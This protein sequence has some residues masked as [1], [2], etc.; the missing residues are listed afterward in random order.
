MAGVKPLRLV[1]SG[2]CGRMGS[3]IIEEILK[4]PA[5][6]ELV[7]G[8]EHDGHPHLGKPLPGAPKIRV[9]KDV[10]RLFGEADLVID[11]T[12]PEA[13]LAHAE[14]AA[15]AA[16]GLVIGTTGFSP[17]QLTRL[18]ELS[19]QVPIFWSPN[20]SIGIVIVRR[21]IASVSK[22]LF[23]FGLTEQ[24]K[25]QISETHHVKKKDKPSGTAKA[26]AEELF[27]ATG[28]LIKEEEIEAKREGEVIGIHSVTF[29]TGPE[30]IT[31]THEATDRRVF[32]Q[33]AVL[34]ARNFQRIVGPRGKGWFGMDDFIK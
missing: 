31:L 15:V 23:D 6:F 16:I 5:H 13:T 14:A 18:Q 24:T 30:K 12:T 11:F 27:K 29:N 4:D 26:L 20:M 28:W 34:V 7:G 10:H 33:G 3:L 1:V 17:D 21:A 19:Q 22:L 32:A 9:S 8:L 2:C 25:A